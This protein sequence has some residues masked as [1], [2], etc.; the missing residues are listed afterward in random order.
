MNK[1][2]IDKKKAENYI[3]ISLA[4]FSFLLFIVIPAYPSS[5]FDYYLIDIIDNYLLG[6]GYYSP[7]NYPFTS[8]VINSF[9]VLLA[10]ILGIFVGIW[11]KDDIE[12]DKITKYTWLGILIIFIMGIYTFF[13]SLN[14]QEF[15]ESTLRRSFGTSQSFHNNPI[16][17]LAMMIG[18]QIWI[19]ISI[20]SSL[21][22]LLYKIDNIRK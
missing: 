4:V 7:P 1:K 9:S 6:N 8:K 17:F 20:R 12:P 18:K 21:A 19:Y 10:I 2:K 22:Y 13:L 14:P 15:R 16:T 3:A 11:R 5:H